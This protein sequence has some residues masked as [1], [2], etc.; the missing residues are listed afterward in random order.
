MSITF[1]IAGSDR[2]YDVL[3]DW[4]IEQVL[5]SQ[6][7]SCSFVIKAGEPP[8]SGD[9]L[10]VRDGQT[11][12]FAGIIDEIKADFKTS[13]VTFY[14]C[15]ARDYS[16]V[17]DRR[18]VVENYKNQSADAIL[19]DIV[20]KYVPG[21][22]VSNVSQ[23]APVIEVMPFY[24]KRPSDCFKDLCKYVGWEWYVDYEK[25][26]HFFNPMELGQQ[27]PIVIN[28]DSNIRKLKHEIDTSTLRNRVYVNGGT[29]LSDPQ[30]IQWKADG[31][32]RTW[33]LP[34]EPYDF[35]LQIG[36]IAK[37][38]G[39]ESV[40]EETDCDYLL[41]QKDKYLRASAQTQTPADGITIQLTAKQAIDVIT[42]VEDLASQQAIAAMQ[43]GDGV[44]EHYVSDDAL[45]TVEAG[46]AAGT[47]D[48]LQHANPKVKG[49]F[50]TEIPGWEPGQLV[51]IDL[52]ARG[53]SGTFLIQKVTIKPAS[54]TLLTFK[55]SYGGRLL[56][57]ADFLKAL[58]SSQKSKKSNDTNV[59]HKY[60]YGGEAAKVQDELALT[61][62]SLP[63]LC[64]NGDAICGLAVVSN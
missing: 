26:L 57:I 7:D 6:E 45:V 27:A 32:G 55:I 9:E 8:V 25:D 46:E 24:Y 11:K 15:T 5:T 22:T 53:I 37:T 58:V 21:F 2:T 39:I 14:E 34:W 56:G 16:Y 49:S 43:G 60:V 59:I 47:A 63:F 13:Q 33:V 64:G 48:L 38:V 10:I 23:E 42:V 31:V 28:N 44:Y 41:K 62:R 36:G 61:P 50:D 51:Y 20:N 40:D 12:I 35:S 54:A 29:M 3:I 52:P 4:S 1:T 18:L 17:I 30:V 19:R